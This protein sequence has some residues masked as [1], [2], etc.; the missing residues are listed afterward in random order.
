MEGIYHNAIGG[1]LQLR[2]GHWNNYQPSFPQY[3]ATQHAALESITHK[4]RPFIP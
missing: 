4:T 1:I 3:A 2:P